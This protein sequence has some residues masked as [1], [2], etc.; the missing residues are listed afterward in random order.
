MFTWFGSADAFTD[1]VNTTSKEGN[2]NYLTMAILWM[3]QPFS[4]RY[5]TIPADCIDTSYLTVAN[6]GVALL[7]GVMLAI[8][9]PGAVLTG[10]IAVW[11]R[12]KRV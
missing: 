2:Y 9:L 3:S 10:S 5:A 8:V 4:S 1:A 11:R 7:W 6:E 12:R